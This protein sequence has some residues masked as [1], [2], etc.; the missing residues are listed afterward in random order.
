LGKE[1]IIEAAGERPPA[2]AW[3]MGAAAW[4]F[5]GAGHLLQG[6]WARAVLLGGTIWGCFVSGFV[7]GGHLFKY[8]GEGPGWSP[9]L[10]IPPMIANLGT[11][12]LYLVCL[13]MGFGFSEENAGRATYEYGWTFLLVAGLLNY[14]AMLDAFDISAGR[15]S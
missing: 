5:P 4:F 2:K 6:H 11:G 12:V 9:L 1:Q 10:Q 15:K 13:M 3:L 14:L 8:S 7:M